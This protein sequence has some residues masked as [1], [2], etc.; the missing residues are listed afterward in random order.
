MAK[1]EAVPW[2]RRLVAGLLSG[3]PGFDSGSVHVEFVV[4]KVA[5]GQVFPRVLWFSPVSFIPPVLH[6]T[7]KRKEKLIIFI[8]G[9]HNKPQGCG[10][11]V[12]SATGPFTTQKKWQRIN[13]A[14][15]RRGI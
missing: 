5:L 6:Y 9:L 4:D 14:T 10:A 8:T 1:N 2:L 3:R 11:F 15:W 12:K 13:P 7:E